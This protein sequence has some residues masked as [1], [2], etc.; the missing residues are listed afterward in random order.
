M[1]FYNS[2]EE[3]GLNLT[4]QTSKYLTSFFLKLDHT[5]SIGSF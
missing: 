3:L 1:E 4:V 5:A 2:I